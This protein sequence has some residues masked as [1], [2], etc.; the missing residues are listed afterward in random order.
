[1]ETIKN[2]GSTGNRIMFTAWKRTNMS[3]EI[4]WFRFPIIPICS[5]SPLFIYCSHAVLT[6]FNFTML[7]STIGLTQECWQIGILNSS[8][9]PREST[10][11]RK[12]DTIWKQ[13]WHRCKQWNHISED[14][15][16]MFAPSPRSVCRLDVNVH[17]MPMIWFHANIKHTGN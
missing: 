5:P 7:D 13:N 9:C 6:V 14:S 4:A 1:M 12:T 17:D 3:D 8:P 10:L 16:W 11:S 15:H 2:N